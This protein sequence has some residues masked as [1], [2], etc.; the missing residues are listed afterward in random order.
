MP[1][2]WLAGE[3]EKYMAEIERA[4]LQLP[5]TKAAAGTMLSL[6]CHGTAFEASQSSGQ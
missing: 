4:I 1:V 5:T 3:S 6:A 2:D